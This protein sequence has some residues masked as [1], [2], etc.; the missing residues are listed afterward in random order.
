MFV[1]KCFETNALI[2]AY[3]N[4]RNNSNALEPRYKGEA[5]T[6]SKIAFDRTL[7]NFFRTCVGPVV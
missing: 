7:I 6:S 2:E 5:H 4:V 1:I 3:G